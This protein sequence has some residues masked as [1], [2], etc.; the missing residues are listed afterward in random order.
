[1]TLNDSLLAP[2]PRDPAQWVPRAKRRDTDFLVDIAGP[3][4]APFRA[5]VR[6]LSASGMLIAGAHGLN[7]GDVLT[8]KMPANDEVMCMIVRVNARGAGVRF[9]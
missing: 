6:N 4:T 9:V 2:A 3:T 5:T 7:V 1:M 8:V